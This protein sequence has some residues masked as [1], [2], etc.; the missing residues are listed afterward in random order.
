MQPVKERIKEVAFQLFKDNGYDNVTVNKICLECKIPK[1]VFY[2]CLLTKDELII[3][4]FNDIKIAINKEIK[5]GKFVGSPITKLSEMFASYITHI[6][7]CGSEII[8][9]LFTINLYKNYKSFVLEDVFSNFC[10]DTIKSG[11]ADGSFKNL[12]SPKNLFYSIYNMFLGYVLR[13]SILAQMEDIKENM[14]ISLKEILI[15]K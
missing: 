9:E 8:S 4:F 14:K 2:K 10:I 12:G 5:E 7:Y 6:T 11:Q 1:Q 13:W 15:V 3:E